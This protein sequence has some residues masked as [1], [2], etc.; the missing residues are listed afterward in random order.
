MR[1]LD[2]H[3]KSLPYFPNGD[4]SCQWKKQV[5][6]PRKMLVED[7]QEFLCESQ[8]ELQ[9]PAA[10]RSGSRDIPHF[11]VAQD[12]RAPSVVPAAS[13]TLIHSIESC[14]TSETAR[15]SAVPTSWKNTQ[16]LLSKKEVRDSRAQRLPFCTLWSLCKETHDFCILLG[17]GPPSWHFPWRWQ[18]KM[19]LEKANKPPHT[20]NQHKGKIQATVV[21]S[22]NS[23]Q[24]PQAT[25]IE[26]TTISLQKQEKGS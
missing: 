21:L 1:C 8:E 16:C 10:N 11:S 6:F 14:W 25:P 17:L 4:L 19:F 13:V 5:L 23:L 2:W 24:R 20:H 26:M 15:G 18:G 7:E 3:E 9:C 12:T 22:Q